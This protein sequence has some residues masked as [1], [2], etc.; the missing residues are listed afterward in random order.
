MILAAIGGRAPDGCKTGECVG[1]SRRQLL[2]AGLGLTGAG[3]L[4]V[5]AA[6]APQGVAAVSMRQS[7]TGRRV[8]Y[9]RTVSARFAKNV[10]KGSLLVAVVSRLSSD[11]LAPTIGTISDD[12]GNHWRQ[13][14]EYFTAH[15]YGVD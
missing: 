14:V 1:L 15:H 8:P 10:Q 4:G 12:S 7:V 9:T 6:A 5:P 3:L 13:A 2:G 11:T